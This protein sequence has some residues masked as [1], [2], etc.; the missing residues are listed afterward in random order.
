MSRTTQTGYVLWEGPSLLDGRPIV[1]ILT[2]VGH[3][4][5]NEKTGDLMQSWILAQGEQP[6]NAIKSGLDGA[7][8]G[9]CPLRPGRWGGNGACYVNLIRGPNFVWR[10]WAAKDY[11][12]IDWNDRRLR[13]KGVR[14]GAYG[15]PAAVPTQVWE[16]LCRVVPG[17][18]G[19]THQW[20]ACDQELQ[21][22]CMASVENQGQALVA[23]G[24][25]WRTFRVRR[26]DELLG[27]HEFACPAS[28]EENK[29]LTCADCMACW[30]ADNKPRA[31]PSIIVHGPPNKRVSFNR[32]ITF[33][34][35]AILSNP[36]KMVAGA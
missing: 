7:V 17:W 16:Q 20:A 2:N 35:V 13:R 19:Y 28:A 1:A 12:P 8:C 3:S 23:Q 11:Q 33:K 21:R 25:G 4:S 24:L 34:D 29:R 36:S 31:N 30:G 5:Q 14:L 32:R 27:Y 10:R 18:V 15:D 9:A 26:A 6:T 22:F